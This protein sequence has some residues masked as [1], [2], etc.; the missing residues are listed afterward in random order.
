MRLIH[1]LFAAIKMLELAASAIAGSA[2]LL[3][4][5]VICGDVVGRYVF[6]SPLAWSYDLISLY[7]MGIG[8]FFALSDTLRRN[9]HVSVDILFNHFRRRTQI[10]W[11]AVGWSLASVLCCIIFVL[12]AQKAYA[13]WSSGEV[14]DGVIA[15]PTW[16]TAATAAVGILL[17]CA[18]LLLGAIA[19]IAAF[20]LNDSRICA[21]AMDTTF[22]NE[23]AR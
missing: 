16:I 11:N 6:N 12:T 10:L 18:R 15:W 17:I 14:I 23:K 4:M 3:I 9:H 7:L 19:H 21:A 8:F 22:E 13:N 1:R 5:F 20:A 2:L